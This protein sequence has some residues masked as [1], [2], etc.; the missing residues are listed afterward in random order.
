MVRPIIVAMNTDDVTN[1]FQTWIDERLFGWSRSAFRGTSAWGGSVTQDQS[2]EGTPDVSDEEDTGDYDNVIDQLD[3][4]TQKSRSRQSSYADLQRLRM[5][6]TPAGTSQLSSTRASSVVD[7]DGLHFR[8]GH[9]ERR[10]S[11]SGQIPVDQIAAVD[12]RQRFDTATAG[13][14]KQLEED[15]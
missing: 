7:M 10:K 13:L 15:A 5:S 8:Q 9:R 14:N 6:S 12:R 11:L 2:A 1:I 3:P 4:L